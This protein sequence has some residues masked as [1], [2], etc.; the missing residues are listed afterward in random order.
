MGTAVRTKNGLKRV[1]GYTA[2]PDDLFIVGRDTRAD[3]TVDGREHCRWDPRAL[4]KPDPDLV[5][6]FK[7]HRRNFLTVVIVVVDDYTEID[8]GRQRVIAAREAQRQLREEGAENPNVLI[9][10]TLSIRGKSELEH[11]LLGQEL[12]ATKVD[13]NDLTLCEKA[14]HALTFADDKGKPLTKTTIA[15]MNGWHPSVVDQAVKIVES[16]S[17]STKQ[18]LND[19][20]ITIALAY[21]LACKPKAEQNDANKNVEV[22]VA[23]ATETAIANAPAG[24]PSP[25]PR[26]IT[27]ADADRGGVA[28]EIVPGK[29]TV[30]RLLDML[31]VAD[32]GGFDGAEIPHLVLIGAIWALQMEL[33][34]TAGDVW[35]ICCTDESLRD[36]ARVK[37]IMATATKLLKKANAKTKA[38]S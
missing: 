31:E 10:T 26:K 5:A 36:G 25:T 38:E 17:A 6:S 27:R 28:V 29:K 16:A 2:D 21:D 8:D 3:G 18:L 12:N 35:D 34:E 11:A 7:K 13:D 19:G 23:K 33:P 37:E 30:A 24:A 20:R 22:L 15:K 14:A 4:Y 1:D 9:Y 32:G